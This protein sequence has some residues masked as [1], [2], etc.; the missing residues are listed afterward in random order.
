MELVSWNVSIGKKQISFLANNFICKQKTLKIQCR[1]NKKWLQNIL[2]FKFP[3]ASSWTSG[4]KFDFKI[5]LETPKPKMLFSFFYFVLI[6]K[7]HLQK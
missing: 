7:I 1:I 4:D 2:N 5:N 3:S 6:K